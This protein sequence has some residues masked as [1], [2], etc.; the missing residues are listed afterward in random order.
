MDESVVLRL[1]Y[2]SLNWADAGQ[3]KKLAD[4][5]ALTLPGDLAG[6]HEVGLVSG[7]LVLLVR[8]CLLVTHFVIS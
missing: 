3:R 8:W 2:K 4:V 5:S 1:A 7:L 6:G